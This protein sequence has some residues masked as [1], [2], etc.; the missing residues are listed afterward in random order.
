MVRE[1]IASHCGIQFDATALAQADISQQPSPESGGL[2]AQDALDA[3]QPLHDELKLMPI[4]WVLEVIP[5]S[6]SWQDDTGRWH[7]TLKYVSH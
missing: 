1:I 3:V 7:R 6:V 5:L 4:W 2:S